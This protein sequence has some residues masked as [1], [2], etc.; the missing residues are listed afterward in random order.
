VG[1]NGSG[2]MKQNSGRILFFLCLALSMAGCTA[3]PVDVVVQKKTAVEQPEALVDEK[4][5]VAE[6]KVMVTEDPV[7]DELPTKVNLNVAFATQAPNSDWGLPY[8]EACEEAAL[9]QARKYFYNEKLDKAIMDVEIKKVVEWETAHFNLYT[10]TALSE[11]KI[12]ADEYFGL[13]VEISEDV[14]VENIKKQLAR[15]FLVIA[16]TA[17]RE[18]G[19]PNFKQPGPIYHF[20]VIRGY[21]GDNFIVNDV[22]TRKGEGYVYAAD[23]LTN[24]IHD[25]AVIDGQIFRPYEEVALE[26]S[27]K[28]A[29]MLTGAP[30]VLIVKDKGD[31][32][33]IADPDD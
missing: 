30:R 10:D 15:G 16:P 32:F 28:Q 6:D 14:S 20:V 23:V 1:Y 17:G 22:G 12:M 31:G 26:D 19:N 29:R 33:K 13:D 18:L 9:I 3:Q 8:Q 2:I 24:A 4:V 25:L 7:V 5:M 27:V 11:V 21:K